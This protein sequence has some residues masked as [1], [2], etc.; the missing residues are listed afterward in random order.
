MLRFQSSVG[1]RASSRRGSRMGASRARSDGVVAV[2]SL[3]RPQSSSARQATPANSA[4][5][6]NDTR[7]PYRKTR[8]VLPLFSKVLT[9]FTSFLSWFLHILGEASLLLIH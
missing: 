4:T 2:L 9:L 8:F 7:Q 6:T 1:R 5:M 3:G